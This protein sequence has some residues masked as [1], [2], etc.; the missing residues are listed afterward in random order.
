M[1]AKSEARSVNGADDGAR[2]VRFGGSVFPMMRGTIVWCRS[3]LW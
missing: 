2:F 3:R 1:A